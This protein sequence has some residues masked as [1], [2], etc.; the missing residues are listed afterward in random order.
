MQVAGTISIMPKISVLKVRQGKVAR[1]RAW[2]R[3]LSERRAEV[4]VT[5]SHEGTRHELVAIVELP[6]HVLIYAIAVV[7]LNAARKA[8][9]EST[10]SR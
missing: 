10:I 2:M 3:E 9:P 6:E 8:L 1:L 5:F 7:D 4:L